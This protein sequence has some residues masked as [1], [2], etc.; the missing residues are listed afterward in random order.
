MWL[1]SAPGPPPWVSIRTGVRW[2]SKWS[3]GDGK[4]LATDLSGTAGAA[5]RSGAVVA[6]GA[7][8]GGRR[9]VAGYRPRGVAGAQRWT[10]GP[11]VVRPSI[12]YHT[13]RRREGPV[14]VA[15]GQLSPCSVT[16]LPTNRTVGGQPTTT[17]RTDRPT[18]TCPPRRR[19]DD[20]D[21]PS[22]GT[23]RVRI[24]SDDAPAGHGH[25]RWVS[26]TGSPMRRPSPWSGPA[27]RP[28][29]G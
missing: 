3:P 5:D 28:G 11:V 20:A 9:P 16:N 7:T 26:T 17:G 18:W 21:E 4:P 12:A 1:P 13:P 14:R 25:P 24:V 27:A 23:P 15:G 19:C 2:W 8:N 29:T 10:A 6:R 22:Q